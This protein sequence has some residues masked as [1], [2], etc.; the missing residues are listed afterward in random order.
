MDSQDDHGSLFESGSL[1]KT[2][3]LS[4]KKKKKKKKRENK[5]MCPKYIN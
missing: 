1:G 4:K 5:D 3:A 2:F